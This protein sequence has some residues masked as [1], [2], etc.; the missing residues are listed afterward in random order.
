MT[1]GRLIRAIWTAVVVLILMFVPPANLQTVQ[2]KQP[3]A[4]ILAS[5]PDGIAL[6]IGQA[7]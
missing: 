4:V 1:M 2:G 6:P 3:I 5:P 7:L